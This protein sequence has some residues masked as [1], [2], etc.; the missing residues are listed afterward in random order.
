MNYD[1]LHPG[2]F[3][4]VKCDLAAG[5]SLQAESDAMVSMST[6]LD[7]KGTVS[8]GILGGLARKFLTG[9]SFFT[10]RITAARGEGRVLLAPPT[11]GDVAAIPLDGSHGLHLQKTSFLAATEGIE[12][13]TK[14]QNLMKG[15][16]SK[17]GFFVINVTGKGV[18]FVSSYGAIHPIV[19][20]AGQEV[21]IDNGHLV[22]WDESM[23][24]SIEK[25]S[26][27]WIS[28]I[29]S[30]ECLVCRFKGPGTIHIQT[31][32]PSGFFNWIRGA[33]SAK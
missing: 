30:G 3:P 26:N 1:I 4:I 24:Y 2:A 12:V 17:E 6:T 33:I 13:Q 10:Q 21:I 27:G 32:N 8:G 16:F 11:P 31:R 15:F 25:A 19:L 14:M 9:E 29:T 20:E 7:I 28:S 23:D 18:L 22:A 5:E